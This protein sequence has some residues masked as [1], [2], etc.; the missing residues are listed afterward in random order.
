MR[1]FDFIF[2][3]FIRDT[4][5]GQIYCFLNVRYEVLQKYFKRK[6]VYLLVVFCLMLVYKVENSN[7]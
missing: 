2:N 4:Q 5:K 7:L 6:L 1:D 3:V